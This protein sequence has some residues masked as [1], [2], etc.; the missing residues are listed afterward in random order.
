MNAGPG[1]VLINEKAPVAALL[2]KATLSVVATPEDKNFVER[3]YQW[4][5]DL[6]A[7]FLTNEIK[8]SLKR[9]D[10]D[11]DTSFQS[12]RILELLQSAFVERHL[13][14]RAIFA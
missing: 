4:A 11:P 8:P 14:D 12:L 10:Y 2:T 13:G 3:G 7:G 6:L 1:D 5:Y 9:G